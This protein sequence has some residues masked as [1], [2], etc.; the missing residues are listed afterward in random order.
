MALAPYTHVSFGKPRPISGG[1]GAPILGSDA[2]ARRCEGVARVIP[3]PSP[4]R[5]SA[6]GTSYMD[7]LTKPR[8][9]INSASHVADR[10]PLAERPSREQALEAVRTLIAW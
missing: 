1:F 8:K 10:S 9:L 7:A 3:G 4:W 2:L 6:P 5:N